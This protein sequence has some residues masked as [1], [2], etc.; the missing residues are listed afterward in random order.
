MT[1]AT[2]IC[3]PFLLS[4]QARFGRLDVDRPDVQSDIDS[5]RQPQESVNDGDARA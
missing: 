3:I 4:L 2:V 1:A 5:E